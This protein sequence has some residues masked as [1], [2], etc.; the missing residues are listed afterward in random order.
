MQ[1]RVNGLSSPPLQFPVTSANPSLFLNIPEGLQ[2]T[3]QEFI[4]VA[5]NADGSQN[6]ATNPAQTGSVISVFVN[7]L[8]TDPDIALEPLQLYAGGGWSVT[9]FSQTNPFVLEVDLQ[10]PSSPVSFAC[11]PPNTSVCTATFE[12]FDLNS[13]LIGSQSGGTGG[14]AFG[15]E[16]YVTQ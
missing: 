2:T 1:V 16:V 5:L 9:N 10:I 3:S 11:Q 4:A 14:L 8:A 15:A 12:I 7:G 6:S 13:Y